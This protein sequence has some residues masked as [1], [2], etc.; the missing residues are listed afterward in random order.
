MK[1]YV[2]IDGG[3]TRSRIAVMDEKGKILE[4]REGG[5]S[6]QYAV[7][8]N[9][10]VQN[11][12]DLV[13]HTANLSQI[14]GFCLASAGLGRKSEVVRMASA[15]R[16]SFPCYYCSDVEALLVG[17]S[18]NENGTCLI[19]GTG[20][21][22]MGRDQNGNTCRSGGFGWRLGDEGSAWWQGQQAIARSMRSKEKRDLPTGMLPCICHQLGV[23]H[24]E[25]LITLCNSDTLSKANIA[26]LSSIVTRYA[27]NND[28]LALS[29]VNDSI[30]ELTMLVD[31]VFVQL[32]TIDG[33]D[34]VCAGG[35]LEHDAFFC[36]L[37]QNAWD[38]R[39][40]RVPAQGTALDGALILAR[41]CREY[42]IISH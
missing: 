6:N 8:L 18:H 33:R 21:V 32:P 14:A 35:V 17:G 30:K 3:G 1:I 19:C 20:S 36:S 16:Y 7:G 28:P 10:A 38:G 11:I 26:A 13:E 37:L 31:S 24:A 25:E 42:H 34:V 22:A 41:A 15:M 27:A 4:K 2:G 23:S 9:M 5:C 39:Y 29:I 12:R 40:R